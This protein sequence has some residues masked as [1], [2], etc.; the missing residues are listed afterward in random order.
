[1]SSM[2]NMESR[3]LTQL[4]KQAKDLGLFDSEWTLTCPLCHAI[5]PGDYQNCPKCS[6]SKSFQ[7]IQID[8]EI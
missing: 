4:I 3:Q 1:M 5:F 8:F 7:N 2:T 6:V